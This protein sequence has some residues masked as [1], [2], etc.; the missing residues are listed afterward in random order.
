MSE[1]IIH[2]FSVE[3]G[4]VTLRTGLG[5]NLVEYCEE[6]AVELVDGGACDGGDEA[7]GG[8]AELAGVEEVANAC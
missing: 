2:S 5:L 1:S 3:V 6:L 7:K 4:R 8:P